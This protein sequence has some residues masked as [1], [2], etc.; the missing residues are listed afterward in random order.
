MILKS[1]NIGPHVISLVYHAGLGNAN[2]IGV[3]FLKNL[4]GYQLTGEE[5]EKYEKSCKKHLSSQRN[6]R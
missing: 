1:K 5:A 4:W 3:Q 6:F 2:D